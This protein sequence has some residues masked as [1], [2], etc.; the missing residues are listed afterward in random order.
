MEFQNVPIEIGDNENIVRCICSPFHVDSKGKLKPGAYEPPPKSDEVSVIRSDIMGANFCKAK[1]KELETAKKFYKG[2][3]VLQAG[4]I[5]SEGAEV[6]DSRIEYEGHADI[7]HGHKTTPGEPPPP[8]IVY[9][10]RERYKKL[11]KIANYHEDPKPTVIDWQG[12]SLIYSEIA[13]S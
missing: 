7:K 8:E 12:P 9:L 13:E 3:A 10:L 4:H 5:R 11:A 2:L 1:A 6:V